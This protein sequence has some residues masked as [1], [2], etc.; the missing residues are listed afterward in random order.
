MPAR[1]TCL[2]FLSFSL[3]CVANAA[4]APPPFKLSGSMRLRYEVIDGQARAA[5]YS[6]DTLANIRTQILA[7]Y[8]ADAIR[9][10]AELFDS[11]AYG[12]D[13][14]TPLT[15]N[16]VNA[17]A[18]VQAYVATDI[19]NP[20]GRGTKLSLMAGR[21]TL[22]L[23]S[24]RLVAADDYRNTTNGYT[25]VRA[26]I[27][28]PDGIKATLIY[29]LPQVRLPDDAAALRDN[30]VRMDR[31]SFDLVLWG[32]LVSKV[33]AIGPA[34]VELSYYHLGE[35]DAPGRPTRDRS[36]DTF[37][38]RLIADPVAGKVDYEIEA[39]YQ[40]GRISRGLAPDASAQSVS[41]TFFHAD[42]GY[43]FA[44]PWKPRLSLEF[45]R[46]SGD[47]SGGHYGR[48]D[49]LF[50]MRRAELAP[51]GLYNSVGRANIATPGVRF[52]AAPSKRLDWFAVYRAMWLASDEDSFST[53]GV[54]DATA[55]SGDFAGHQVEGRIRYWLRPS[56]LRFEVNALLLAKG[57]FLRDA[58]NA[59]PQRTTRYASFNLTA[60]F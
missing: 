52:E 50:G 60:S 4:D 23:G 38:M 1:F 28:A 53:T 30:A 13:P 22:N 32:G 54:R 57:H 40:S 31:E 21:F 29:T 9:L 11:R 27:A 41:A 25:G 59:P 6:S 39:I 20:L 12:A 36:L 17:V 58:P 56:R 5:F 49:T 35:R 10:G 33:K 18:L 2:V 34:M 26:D 55:R 46:A 48:F 14:G 47:K 7:E 37:G 42:V 8:N 16:E 45:D 43:S 19:A 51:A 3:S 44:G 24:R 15:T